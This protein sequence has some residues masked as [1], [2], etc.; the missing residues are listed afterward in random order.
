[1]GRWSLDEDLLMVM[2]PPSSHE[3][4]LMSIPASEDVSSNVGVQDPV[5]PVLAGG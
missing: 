4:M 5:A 2:A 1:M 3:L